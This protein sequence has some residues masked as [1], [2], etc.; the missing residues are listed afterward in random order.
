MDPGLKACLHPPTTQPA[1][2]DSENPS[3]QSLLLDPGRGA[4][5]AGGAEPI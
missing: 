3:A 2:L 4:M 5:G 1:H